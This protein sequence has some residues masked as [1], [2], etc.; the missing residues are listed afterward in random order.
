MNGME[1]KHISAPYSITEQRG[2]TFQSAQAVCAIP[3]NSLKL[4]ENF[5]LT[6]FM[7]FSLNIADTLESNAS[8]VFINT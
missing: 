1:K 2:P 8:R 6:I 4:G 5:K 3:W 7:Q